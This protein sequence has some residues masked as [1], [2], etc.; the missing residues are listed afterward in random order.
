MAFPSFELDG[1]AQGLEFVVFRLSKDHSLAITN[2]EIQL[3][4]CMPPQL[5]E[6]Q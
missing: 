6:D 2:V 1:R 4:G 5:P 3:A